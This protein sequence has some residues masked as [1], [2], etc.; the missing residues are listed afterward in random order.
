MHYTTRLIDNET[1]KKRVPLKNVT[2]MAQVSEI[3]ADNLDGLGVRAISRKLCD[4]TGRRSV[5][6]RTLQGVLDQLVLHD[7]VA[8]SDTKRGQ[9][10]PYFHIKPFE[11]PARPTHTKASIKEADF[12]NVQDD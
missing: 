12:S 5:Q 10:K 2:M 8:T 7:Y 11:K 9:T 6:T 3:L 4:V 1:S